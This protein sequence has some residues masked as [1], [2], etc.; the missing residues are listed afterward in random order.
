M[1]HS[2]GT[3]QSSTGVPVGTSCTSSG[4]CSA[5]MR[6]VSRT[7]SPV[8]LRQNRVEALDERACTLAPSLGVRERRALDDF[9]LGHRNDEAPA[10]RAVLGLLASTSSAKFQASSNT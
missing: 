2:R 4:I 6:S 5:R 9:D 8:R 10:S 1:F 7:P 3:V